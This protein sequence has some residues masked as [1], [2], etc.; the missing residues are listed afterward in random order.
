MCRLHFQKKIFKTGTALW[1][2]LVTGRLK[3]DANQLK[4]E[5]G[6]HQTRG[7][8]LRLKKVRTVKYVRRYVRS[9]YVILCLLIREANAWNSLPER[10]VASKSVPVYLS[11]KIE[12]KDSSRTRCFIQIKLQ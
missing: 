3:A 7:H 10:V 8:S 2:K 1:P 12:W 6:P 5:K 9:M 11:S 4:I